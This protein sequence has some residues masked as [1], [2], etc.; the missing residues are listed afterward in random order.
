[1]RLSAMLPD[2]V[3]PAVNRGMGTAAS[4]GGTKQSV[5]L[6]GVV[7]RVGRLAIRFVGRQFPGN[8]GYRAGDEQ[9]KQHRKYGYQ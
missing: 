3:R 1:M 7:W 5:R 8:V 9:R 2:R 4:T 6:A